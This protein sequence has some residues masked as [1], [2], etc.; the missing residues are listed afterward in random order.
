[1][2]LSRFAEERLLRILREQEAGARTADVS[3]TRARG[4]TFYKCKTKYRAG[5]IRCQATE[6]TGE[7][8]HKAEEVPAETMLDN[9]LLRTS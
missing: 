2:K 9:A 1:M 7:R 3:Q 6:G 8:Q 4:T 5:R